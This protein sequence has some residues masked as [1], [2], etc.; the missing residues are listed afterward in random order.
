M[1][2]YKAFLI[3]SKKENKNM[4]LGNKSFL[5]LNS[6]VNLLHQSLYLRLCNLTVNNVENFTV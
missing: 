4:N 5:T 1:M 6:K 2:V 3:H